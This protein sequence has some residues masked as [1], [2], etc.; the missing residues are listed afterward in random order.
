MTAECPP[1]PREYEATVREVV[2]HDKWDIF[3][4]MDTGALFELN[5]RS[6]RFISKFIYISDATG[7]PQMIVHATPIDPISLETG[8]RE[9][10]Q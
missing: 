1:K 6:F 2:P 9:T 7:L 8:N 5:E 10:Q 4:R 3:R